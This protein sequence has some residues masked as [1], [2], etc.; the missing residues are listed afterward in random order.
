MPF[1]KELNDLGDLLAEM[2]AKQWEVSPTEHRRRL[3]QIER[4]VKKNWPDKLK[5]E[6]A[7]QKALYAKD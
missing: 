3:G 4:I 1:V 2:V 5:A 7:R 6:N